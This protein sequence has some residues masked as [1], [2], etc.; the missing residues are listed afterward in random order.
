[1]SWGWP[2]AGGF[3]WT[4]EVFGYP[5]TRGPA[6]Q[7]PIVA[8]LTGPTWAVREY[9]VLDAG[10]I[11]GLAGPEATTGYAGVTWNIGR[12]WR[13]GASRQN[14]QS[15]VTSARRAVIR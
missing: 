7:R 10:I 3:G 8:L 13:A 6:G 14:R 9:L 5:G 4:A 11:V 12:L 1:M 2:I 15:N